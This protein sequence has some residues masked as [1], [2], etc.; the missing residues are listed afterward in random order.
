[1][2]FDID[3]LFDIC[4]E[5]IKRFSMSHQ[6]ELFYGFAIDASL[7]CLNSEEKVEKLLTEYCSKWERSTLFINTWDDLTPKDIIEMEW[8]FR[9][10]AQYEGLDLDDKQEC[11]KALNEFRGKKR[12]E[13]NPYKT[14]SRKND[15]RENTGDWENQGFFEMTNEVGFDNEAYEKHYDMN[16]EDQKK[17]EYGL[18]MDKLIEKLKIS[19][20]FEGLK[21]TQDFYAI[22]VEHDY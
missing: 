7:L 9:Q 3:K 1:M 6:D 13:G 16:E 5:E 21:T 14:K 17:S 4:V 2:S 12:K 15:L 19:K 22:R 11:I 20:V 8:L 18:A 10:K